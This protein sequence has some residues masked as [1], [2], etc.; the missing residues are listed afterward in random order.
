MELSHDLLDLG[1]L[2]VRVGATRA[3]ISSVAINQYEC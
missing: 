1:I 3:G 2:G